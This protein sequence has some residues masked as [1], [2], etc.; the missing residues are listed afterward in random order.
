[1][2]RLEEREVVVAAHHGT[3]VTI[4]THLELQVAFVLSTAA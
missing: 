2:L 4:N 3:L 1:M